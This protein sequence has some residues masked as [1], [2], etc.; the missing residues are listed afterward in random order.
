MRQDLR[1]RTGR[2]IQISVD[3]V[4]SK[5]ELAE[6]MERLARPVPAAPEVRTAAEI[7]EDLLARIGPAIR[8]IWPSSDAPMQGFNVVLG[9][10][11]V[12]IEVRYQAEKDLGDV[13]MGMVL[14]DLR[15][16]LG[17]PTLTLKAERTSPP[18][19]LVVTPPP[20]K[21]P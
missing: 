5:S 11:G 9:T 17:L 20:R 13:P 2:E 19:A 1:R 3:A 21:R 14:R 16:K 10:D 8:A 12:A 15:T 7:Q 4:A 18:P 6:L